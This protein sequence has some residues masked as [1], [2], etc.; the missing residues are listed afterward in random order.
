MEWWCC[1]R[2]DMQLWCYWNHITNT[3]PSLLLGC[4]HHIS[5]TPPSLHSRWA[6]NYPDLALYCTLYSQLHLRFLEQLLNVSESQAC[7]LMAGKTL[8]DLR[9]V[10]RV[11]NFA[12]FSYIA[13][14]ARSVNR[15]RFALPA[16]FICW[17]FCTKSD[18]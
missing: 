1:H 18:S 9:N 4:S 3:P 13:R 10:A 12:N 2:F 6:A 8:L 14:E 15:R 17:Y 5:P 16:M 7:T 11:T